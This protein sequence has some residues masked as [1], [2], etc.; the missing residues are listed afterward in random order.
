M[1]TITDATKPSVADAPTRCYSQRLLNPFRGIMSVVEVDG[2]DAVSKDGIH[3]SLYVHGEVDRELGED[4]H[5]REIPLPDIKYGTWSAETGL[6]RAPIRSVAD[7]EE[8]DT[9]GQRVLGA[10]KANCASLPFPISDHFELWLLA[11][12]D[13]LP[14][15]L[16][17]AATEHE[18]RETPERPAWRPGKAAREQF[19]GPD[20]EL[21]DAEA[22][23]EALARIV[24]D[25]AGLQPVAQW[26]RRRLDGIGEGM[27]INSAAE[28]MPRR[29]LPAEAFPELLLRDDWHNPE[30]GALI[31]A[32][33]DWQSPWLLLLQTLHTD[34]RRRLERAARQ[35]AIETSR[36]HHLYPT[37]I[38]PDGLKVAL[39]EARLRSAVSPPAKDD[40]EMP[41]SPDPIYPF[42]NE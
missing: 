16:I 20:H 32:Y 15:T 2:A 1:R 19:H 27:E 7:Y 22:D 8:I 41:L 14:L 3:W 36:Q 42:F 23:C 33:L 24:N 25:R 40:E 13:F 5:W 30:D 38:D 28:T 37:V 39:V 34:T 17:A 12:D 26:F 10:I 29:N 21:V 35:R 11:A 9:T 31:R 4:G 18:S 6:K